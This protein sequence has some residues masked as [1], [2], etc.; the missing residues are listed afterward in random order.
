MFIFV[1]VAGNGGDPNVCD[2][3]KLTPLHKTAIYS[4]DARLLHVLCENGANINATDR[5]GNSPLLS[6]CDTSCTD[7]YEY[8]EDLSMCSDDTLEDSCASL[9]VKQEFLTYL[10]SLKDLDVSPSVNL[11]KFKTVNAV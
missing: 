7:M 5:K 11:V 9:C 8:F 6:M 10:I 4:H 2:E 1:L 3:C